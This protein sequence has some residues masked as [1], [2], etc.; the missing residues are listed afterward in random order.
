MSIIQIKRGLNAD[1]L[2]YTP[3]NGELIWTDDTKELYI[4]DGSTV[5]GLSTAAA[6]ASDYVLTSAKGAA[7][8]VS[9]LGAD[10]KIIDAQLPSVALTTVVTVADEAAMLALTAEE[11][12]VA[13]REDTKETFVFNGGTAGT[14]A[15]W[16]TMAT[17][18][19]SV[20]SVNGETGVIVLDTDDIDV[21]T[22]NFYL[23]TA[24]LQEIIDD[25]SAATN[26]S[27]SPQ[28]IRQEVTALI[29]D[30]LSSSSGVKT[31]TLSADK[32]YA[33]AA[34]GG[35]VQAAIDDSGESTSTLYSSSKIKST[36]DALVSTSNSST[37][38]GSAIDKLKVALSGVSNGWSGTTLNTTTETN[39]TDGNGDA[40]PDKDHYTV[41]FNSNDG[42]S[43]TLPDLEGDQGDSGDFGTDNGGATG[44]SF[45]VVST[46]YN[47][48][49]GILKI[50]CHQT[51]DGNSDD[52]A[53]TVF[54]ST[55]DLRTTD[56]IQF[57][58]DNNANSTTG[59]SSSKI[60]QKVSIIDDS[61]TAGNTEKVF[62]AD[63]L[64]Q[65]L[66][67][68]FISINDSTASDS[69][70][71]SS[72]KAI[73]VKDS[74]ISDT[75]TATTK[76]LSVD[77]IKTTITGYIDDSATDAQNNTSAVFSANKIFSL[78][79]DS[80]LVIDD[81]T[82]SSTKVYS[83]TKIDSM[84]DTISGGTL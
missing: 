20:I 63:K 51:Q 33:I 60:N 72:N 48:N 15:D 73:A 58:D 74:L 4:G 70:A 12:D 49:T 40:L 38:A 28:K 39:R 31:K 43:F 80:V 78:V 66:G 21:G 2:N 68:A 13:V 46:T 64:Y 79:E 59:Y 11:G 9:S 17:P 32:I 14:I 35:A 27:W 67:S 61:A 81:S 34:D 52:L 75:S 53:S 29:D 65:K 47:K 44:Y 26:L 84:F 18:T 54:I 3:I 6:A 37:T 69:T 56:G 50:G 19:D 1:R 7:N 57:I 82:K 71:Y 45:E 62:S 16:S 36:I 30:T 25:A 22:S 5:G 41:T 10:S 77:K 23:T 8:G 55:G 76:A 24:K 83:S 42:L